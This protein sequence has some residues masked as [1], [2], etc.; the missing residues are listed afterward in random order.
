MAY[1]KEEERRGVT[2]DSLPLHQPAAG[3]RLQER[4]VAGRR[5]RE[6]RALPLLPRHSEALPG[7]AAGAAVACN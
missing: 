2:A 1:G 7:D 4:R 6:V 3:P 5:Q